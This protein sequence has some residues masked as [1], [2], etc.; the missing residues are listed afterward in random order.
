MSNSSMTRYIL[1]GLIGLAIAVVFTAVSNLVRYDGNVWRTLIIAC[2]SAVLAAFV[3]F[4]LG[5]SRK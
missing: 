5:R 4:M 1:A 2:L 3:G